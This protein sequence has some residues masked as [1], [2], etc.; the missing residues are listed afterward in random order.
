MS[1]DRY[2]PTFRKRPHRIGGTNGSLNRSAVQQ[3]LSKNGLLDSNGA[4]NHK[5]FFADLEQK[6]EQEDLSQEVTR[7]VGISQAI[8]EVFAEEQARVQIT[9]CY[10]LLDKQFPTFNP[11]APRDIIADDYSEESRP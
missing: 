8:L 3:E 7:E 5:G 2:R 6:P 10:A 11:L 9:N 4:L 1:K